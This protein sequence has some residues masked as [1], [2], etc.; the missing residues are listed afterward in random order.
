MSE[1]VEA[2]VVDVDALVKRCR[3]GFLTLGWLHP[4]FLLPSAKSAIRVDPAVGTACVDQRGVITLAPAFA[5]TLSDPELHFVL[6]HE[7][8]HLLMLHFE[9]RGT[10][11]PV[12]WNYAAD[13]AINRALKL[14]GFK[15][16]QGLLFPR[17]PAHERWTAEQLYDVEPVPPPQTGAPRPG[18]GCGTVPAR[19][20]VLTGQ[21]E[22]PRV[23]LKDAAREWHRIAAAARSCAAGAGAGT[24]ALAELCTLPP[25]RVRWAQVLRGG[26]ARAVAARGRDD[27][28]WTR[29]SRRSHSG[30]FI[31]P[32]GVTLGTSA[33]VIIDTSGSVSDQSLHQAIADTIAISRAAATRVYLVTHDDD[34]QWQGWLTPA[35]R[36]A[37]IAAACRGRGGTTFDAAYAAVAAVQHR[38][39]AAVHLTDGGVCA[40]PARPANV[41]KLVVALLG[42]ASRHAIPKDAQVVETELQ[43]ELQS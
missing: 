43:T 33:A 21:G 7:L 36:P 32:G 19:D 26:L 3:R 40:W 4:F 29:R 22:A 35:A 5:A 14:S 23:P 41:R 18:E 20:D 17:D 8:M 16:P 2:G 6:A 9:R 38:F 30:D 13:R 15:A 31:L 12:R 34:V 42:S 25:S 28:S 27:Q 1:L 39:D 24:G 37:E 11:E 10:R